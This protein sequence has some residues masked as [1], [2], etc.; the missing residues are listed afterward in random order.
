MLF[1]NN[2]LLDSS[3]NFINDLMDGVMTLS[4][5]VTF[6][7]SCSC[8][9]GVTEHTARTSSALRTV[10]ALQTNIN[11]THRITKTESYKIHKDFSAAEQEITNSPDKH[12]KQLFSIYYFYI[13]YIYPPSF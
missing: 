7:Q 13:F 8:T 4:G 6:S 2:I 11:R 12:I 1:V 5:S 9:L 10:S 3:S